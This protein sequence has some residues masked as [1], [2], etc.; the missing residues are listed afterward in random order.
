M[1]F[2]DTYNINSPKARMSQVAAAIDALA[3]S[4]AEDGGT[5]AG[6][7]TVYT[8][9]VRSSYVAYATGDLWVIKMDEANTGAM[10][11]NGNGIGAKNVYLLTGAIVALANTVRAG[12]N[13]IYRYDATLNAAAGGWYILNP[14]QGVKFAHA[15]VDTIGAPVTTTSSTMATI[16]SAS[17][18]LTVGAHELIKVDVLVTCSSSVAGDVAEFDIHDGTSALFTRRVRIDNA[19]AANK[20]YSHQAAFR[21]RAL[22][23]IS[24]AKTYSLRWRRQAG[25]GTLECGYYSIEVSAET[26]N[27]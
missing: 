11:L 22:G 9:T 27:N 21:Y 6:S 16:G 14:E 1:S 23:G 15:N 25:T 26:L 17:V 10:T 7:S 13:Y 3:L 19:V 20:G 18:S 24:G 8:F 2:S 12:G 5:S 4:K